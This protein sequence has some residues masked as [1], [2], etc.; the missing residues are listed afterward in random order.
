M[1]LLLLSAV[2]AAAGP[3]EDAD[4]AY[5]RKDYKTAAQD[6]TLAASQAL[7]PAT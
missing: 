2:P 7:P 1:A 3:R 5:V 4:A 6:F